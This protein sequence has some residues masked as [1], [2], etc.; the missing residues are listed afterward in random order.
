MSAPSPAPGSAA[1]R[2]R[3]R[4][5]AKAGLA[6]T[7]ATRATRAVGM[8]LELVPEAA[9]GAA[10]SLRVRVLAE[11]R[12]LAGALVR[13]WRTPLDASGLPRDPAARDSVGPSWQV[14]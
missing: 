14:R 2:C 1:R 11:G 5:C 12:P 9:P 3:S 7:D 6:G 4:R 13:V 10:P 8:P